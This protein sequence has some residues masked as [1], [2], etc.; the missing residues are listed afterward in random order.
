LILPGKLQEHAGKLVL[1]VR[2]ERAQRFHGV[3][4][5]LGHGILNEVIRL[6]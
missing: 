4:E 5:K 3:F 1:H 6:T 2:R